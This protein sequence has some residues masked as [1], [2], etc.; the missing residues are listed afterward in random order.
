V[1]VGAERYE[2]GAGRGEIDGRA[3]YALG[4][5][6]YD[7]RRPPFVGTNRRG[8]RHIAERPGSTGCVLT[9]PAICRRIMKALE[10]VPADRWQT[11]EVPPGVTA[12][13][14]RLRGRRVSPLPKVVLAAA[15]GT[16]GLLGWSDIRPPGP[17]T[18]A[19][20]AGAAVRQ[21]PRRLLH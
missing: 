21:P 19:L 20:D 3:T 4:V 2:P 13:G 12:E 16:V 6:A 8:S 18:S 5:A 10:K 7:A 15:G 14:A 11:G 1:A 9:A 17:P